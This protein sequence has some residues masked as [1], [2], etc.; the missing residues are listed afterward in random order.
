MQAHWDK[1]ALKKR[2]KSE[3]QRGKTATFSWVYLLSTSLNNKLFTT[4]FDKYR[5]TKKGR[6]QGSATAPDLF[7]N[8]ATGR[9]KMTD[10]RKAKIFLKKIILDFELL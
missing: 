2:S 4:C 10:E 3:L 8:N 5:L 9:E 7:T 6:P 1:I